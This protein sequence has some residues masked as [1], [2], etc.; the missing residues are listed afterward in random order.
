M[1][2]WRRHFGK[3]SSETYARGYEAALRDLGR[4]SVVL[5]AHGIVAWNKARP[6]LTIAAVFVAFVAGTCLGHFAR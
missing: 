5:T 3:H 1:S 2:A 4:T 6:W